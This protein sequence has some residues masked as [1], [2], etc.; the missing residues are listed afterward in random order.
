MVRCLTSFVADGFNCFIPSSDSSVS[1]FHVPPRERRNYMP[2]VLS[3]FTSEFKISKRAV[4]ESYTA[5]SLSFARKSV[6]KN[7]VQVSVRASLRMWLGAWHASGKWRSHQPR[8]ARASEDATHY[9]RVTASHIA[10][11][12]TAHRFACVVRSSLRSSRGFF[13]KKERLLAV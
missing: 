12:L 5:S 3:R 8:V 10:R 9:L 13:S 1:S 11:R 2:R 7:T 6:G 4:R